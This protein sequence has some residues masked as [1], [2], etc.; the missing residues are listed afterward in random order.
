[1]KIYT[2]MTASGLAVGEQIEKTRTKTKTKN[3]IKPLTTEK[4]TM[5]S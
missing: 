1:M 4:D 5:T 2:G 3:P